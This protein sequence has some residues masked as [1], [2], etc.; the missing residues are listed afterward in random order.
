MNTKY[1]PSPKVNKVWV[2]FQYAWCKHHSYTEDIS[3]PKDPLQIEDYLIQHAL[4]KMK[5]DPDM[6]PDTFDCLENVWFYIDEQRVGRWF[7]IR[8]NP[9]V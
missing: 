7:D 9:F 8:T 2:C 3:L 6:N 4:N 1:R 5:N